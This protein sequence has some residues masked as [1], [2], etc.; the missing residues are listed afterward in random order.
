MVEGARLESVYTPQGY[1]GFESHP[2][3][4][5]F[6]KAMQNA[7]NPMIYGVFFVLDIPISS[8]NG[9][10]S[11]TDFISINRSLGCAEKT[12]KWCSEIDFFVGGIE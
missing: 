2:L 5:F 11:V 10:V 12:E 4:K 9:K 6:Y 8:L 3:C 7:V 1:R